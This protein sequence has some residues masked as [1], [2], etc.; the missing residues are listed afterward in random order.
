MTYSWAIIIVGVVVGLLLYYG[1]FTPSAYLKPEALGFSTFYIPEGGW[2]LTTDGRLTLIAHNQADHNVKVIRVHVDG[3]VVSVSTELMPG[4]T[5]RL[6][7]DQQLSGRSRS[8]GSNYRLKII[9]EYND[10]ITKLI[11]NDTGTL[12][13]RYE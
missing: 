11:H 2:K 4:E 7:D 5:T 6:L 10:T 9:I 8:L 1:I 13:G 3:E 12:I